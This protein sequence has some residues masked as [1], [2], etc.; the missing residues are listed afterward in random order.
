M[1]AKKN[2]DI[3]KAHDLLT[4]MSKNE[5]AEYAHLNFKSGNHIQP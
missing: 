4:I 2:K 5:K 3:E 1:L